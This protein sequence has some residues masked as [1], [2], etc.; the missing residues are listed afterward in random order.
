VSTAV[1]YIHA[2]WCAMLC[3]AVLLQRDVPGLTRAVIPVFVSK[4]IKAISVGVNAGSAP[5][6]VPKCTP[7]IWRDEAIVRHTNPGLLAPRCGAH[8]VHDWFH[9]S[10]GFPLLLRFKH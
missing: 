4:G 6:G 5:P 2:L 7:F 3:C 8:T 1:R 10:S 9:D